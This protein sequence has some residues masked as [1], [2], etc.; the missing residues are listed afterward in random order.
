MANTTETRHGAKAPAAAGGA[1]DLFV[2]VHAGPT[3]ES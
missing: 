1:W 2:G 3:G